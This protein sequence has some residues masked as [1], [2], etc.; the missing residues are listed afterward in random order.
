MGATSLRNPFS[1]VAINLFLLD[2][3]AVVTP[4]ALAEV[5]KGRPGPAEQVLLGLFLMRVS[6]VPERPSLRVLK[7]GNP[8]AHVADKQIFG[9]SDTLGVV[10]LTGDRKFLRVLA[11]N[12]IFLPY[13]LVDPPPRYS[14]R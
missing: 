10:T 6:I 8:E 12:K 5:R 9:T 4:T 14:Q 13:S 1:I 3:N 7:V 11:G 2:K